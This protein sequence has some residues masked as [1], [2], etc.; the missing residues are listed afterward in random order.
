MALGGSLVAVMHTEV[1]H[2]VPALEVVQEHWPGPVGVYPHSGGWSMPHWQFEQII[3][4]E[5]FVAE[6]QQWVRMGVQLIGGCC[7]IG[8]EHIQLLNDRLSQRGWACP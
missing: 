2:T 1:Q 3:S 5:D 7:G 8:P 4:P 6:A